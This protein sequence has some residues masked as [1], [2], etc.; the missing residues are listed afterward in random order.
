MNELQKKYVEL[1]KIKYEFKDRLEELKIVTQ[2]LA[3]NMGIGGHFADEEG[4]VYQIEKAKGTYVYFQEFE[5]LRTRR[6]G[7]KKGTL[8]MFKA[9]ELGY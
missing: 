8:S 2:A 3:E 7:E 6:E 9:K 4:T 1:E 5:V